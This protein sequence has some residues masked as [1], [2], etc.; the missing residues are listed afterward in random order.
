MLFRLLIAL[1]LALSLSNAF[2]AEVIDEVA[3][4]RIK[5][6]SLRHSEVGKTLGYLS[7]V[8]GPRL[9]GTPRYLEMVGWAAAQLREWG[10]EN[11]WTER[12]G[13]GLRGWEVENFSATMTSPSFVQ[14][15]AQPVCCSGGTGGVVTGVPL[16]LDFYDIEALQASSGKLRGRECV[17][18]AQCKNQSSQ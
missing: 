18:Q 16:P 8:Y 14:L 10:I 6:E 7:D 1:V 12:Y 3:I 17:A 11:V 5:A 4:A 13:D 15:N 9:T 2:S